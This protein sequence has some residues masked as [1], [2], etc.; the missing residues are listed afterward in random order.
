MADRRAIR[1]TFSGLVLGH[2]TAVNRRHVPAST[3]YDLANSPFAAVIAATVYPAY[4]VVSVV[5]NA[6]GRAISGGEHGLHL[7]GD[8]GA[9]LPDPGRHC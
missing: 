6:R 5:G 3:L 2:A 4:Y 8:C 1:P 9:D 7:H